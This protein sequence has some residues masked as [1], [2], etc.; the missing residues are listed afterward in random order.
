MII[1]L[2]IIIICDKI[3]R[4]K[5]NFCTTVL[6]CSNSLILFA[7]LLNHSHYLNTSELNLYKNVCMLYPKFF[8]EF[9]HNMLDLSLDNRYFI[10][11]QFSS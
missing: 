4:Q 3:C 6:Y 1:I 2:K 11:A 10:N 5:G 8:E 9:L 7:W